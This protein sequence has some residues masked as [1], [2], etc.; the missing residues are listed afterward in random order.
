MHDKIEVVIC[1]KCDKTMRLRMPSDHGLRVIEYSRSDYPH[2]FVEIL[3]YRQETFVV[4]QLRFH[5][6]TSLQ[7]RYACTFPCNCIVSNQFAHKDTRAVLVSISG[8][9]FWITAVDRRRLSKEMYLDRCVC[10]FM[11]NQMW[12]AR[13]PT[14]RPTVTMGRT[15]SFELEN[16]THNHED[17][18]FAD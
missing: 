10:G 14:F 1:R 9:S 11:R 15:R 3:N 4:H 18:P 5:D 12:M 6:G 16:S 17:D 13:S 2:K 8:I 7:S